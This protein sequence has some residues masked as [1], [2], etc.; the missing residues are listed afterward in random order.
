MGVQMHNLQQASR[1]VGEVRAVL[2][3]R[4]REV[5]DLWMD[6]QVGRH[7][8]GH[9]TRHSHLLLNN[10]DYGNHSSKEPQTPHLLLDHYILNGVRVVWEWSEM[11]A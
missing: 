5:L 7:L 4:D 2:H 3:I 11:V 6:E 9:N 1:R 8:R 10:L